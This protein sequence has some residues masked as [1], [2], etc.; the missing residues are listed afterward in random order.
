MGYPRVGVAV[1]FI[2]PFDR[3]LIQEHKP[4]HKISGVPRAYGPLTETSEPADEGRMHATLMRGVEEELGINPDNLNLYV[5]ALSSPWVPGQWPIADGKNAGQQ[6]LA[7][8][9]AVFLDE[10]SAAA[11]EQRFRSTETGEISEVAFLSP[12]EI[13]SHLPYL[14]GGTLDWLGNI[15]RSGLLDYIGD[16]RQL[17]MTQQPTR[18]VALV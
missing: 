12:N 17:Q 15:E 7:V 6:I 1:A 4:S 13:R 11:I 2:D 14:R 16:F 9:L 8:N 3:I 10:E 5:P 18:E